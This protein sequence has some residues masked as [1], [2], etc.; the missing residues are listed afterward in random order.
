MSET[1]KPCPFCGCT[2]VYPVSPSLGHSAWRVFCDDCSAEGPTIQSYNSDEAE[3]RCQW[4]WNIR[5][6]QPRKETQQ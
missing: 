1:L 3:A 2:N 4:V 5:H 6:G